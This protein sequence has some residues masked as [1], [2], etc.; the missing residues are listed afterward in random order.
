MG[1]LYNAITF[2]S[3]L[4]RSIPWSPCPALLLITTPPRASEFEL[5]A[6]YYFS[7]HVIVII[8]KFVSVHVKYRMFYYRLCVMARGKVVRA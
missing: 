8:Y 6:A 5:R 2:P 1:L 7:P 3:L 4:A